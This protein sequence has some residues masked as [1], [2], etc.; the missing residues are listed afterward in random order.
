M[1]RLDIGTAYGASSLIAGAQRSV[2][3][4]VEQNAQGAPSQ[5]TLYPRPGLTPLG[6]GAPT[7]GYSRALYTATNGDLYAVVNQ[8]LYYI[9]PNWMWHQSGALVTPG[10]APVSIADN[11]Q[12]AI[13]VDGSL[14]G[15]NINLQTRVAAQIVDPNFLGGTRVTFLN[16]FLLLNE[17]NS[18]NFYS[19]EATTVVF[20]ALFFGSLTEYPGNVVGLIASEAALWIF[21]PYKGE[22]W[23]DAGT[24]P[25]AFQPLSGII[26]EHGLAGPYA[27]GR[28]DVN[29]YWLSQ[30]P[31]GS[32]LAMRGVGNG[33][34]RISTHA[35]EREWLKYPIVSDCIVTAYQIKGHPFV[36]YDFPTA[37]RTWVWDEIIQEW[38]EEAFYD[39][40]GVQHRNRACFKAYAYGKNVALDW[41]T[42]ALYQLDTTNFSDNGVAQVYIRD[43]PHLVD[44]EDSRLT[45]WRTMADVSCGG[46]DSPAVPQTTSPWSAGWSPGFGPRTLTEPPQMTLCIS[47]DRGKTYFPHS[48]QYMAGPYG[49]NTRPTFN[50]CGV[51]FDTVLRFQWA[52]PFETAMQGA[53][54]VTEQHEGD[55]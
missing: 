38:H 20:N 24:S 55:I 6:A 42:G 18:P 22:V 4:Y 21:G 30:S 3:L 23:A 10:T 7:V 43:F 45:I 2:N 13:V 39:V 19:T 46:G 50:R 31:E 47:H 29:I 37:D 51:S 12:N 32:R 16:F 1:P 33:A 17:L 9:D 34:Q 15:L 41:Q 27:L 52:G 8:T 25:F 14:F 26:L 11:G 49:F 44:S 53:F 28:Q 54:V 36:C 35:I 40:N 48:D 5:R